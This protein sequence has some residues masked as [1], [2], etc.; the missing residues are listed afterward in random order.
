MSTIE[1]VRDNVSYMRDFKPLTAEEQ[2]VVARA[3]EALAGVH[4]YKCTACHYCTDG[5]PM[6]IPIPDFFKAMNRKLIFENE[7]D[8][9]RRY[10]QTAEKAGVN[11]SDCIACGQCEAACPQRLPII[12]YLAEVASELE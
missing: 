7:A 12:E 5:C 3:Q 1:Q 11:A 10:Q 6:G 4:Q 9:K 2:A 8:A